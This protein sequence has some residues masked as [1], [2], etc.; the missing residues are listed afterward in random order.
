MAAKQSEIPEIPEIPQ[1][2]Q[3]LLIKR[4]CQWHNRWQKAKAARLE[5]LFAE[6]QYISPDA[7]ARHLDRV[8]VNY[9][10]HYCEQ[11]SPDIASLQGD[12]SQFAVYQQVRNHI[13]KGIAARYPWLS[14]ECER[15][16]FL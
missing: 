11:K 7:P 1:W 4:A 6:A 15:Q 3:S 14:A 9:L 8:V 2:P 5:D 12:A 13:L 10:R 16:N